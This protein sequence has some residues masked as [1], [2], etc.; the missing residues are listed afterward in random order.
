VP[1]PFLSVMLG[2]RRRRVLPVFDFGFL[3]TGASWMDDRRTRASGAL[4]SRWRAPPSGNV[5]CEDDLN[6]LDGAI[7]ERF[8]NSLDVERRNGEDSDTAFGLDCIGKEK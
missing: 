1:S 3:S 7:T 4:Y 5:S 6:G 2:R 8:G